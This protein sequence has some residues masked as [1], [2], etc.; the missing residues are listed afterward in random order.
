MFFTLLTLFTAF[1]NASNTP[2]CE[3]VYDKLGIAHVNVTDQSHYYYCF[4]HHHGRD[5]A[6]QMD[7]FKRVAL[8]KNAELYGFSALKTDLMM[9]L[10][11]LPQ[12]ADRLFNELPSET[13]KIL[14]DYANGVNAGFKTGKEAREFK[15]LDYTPSLWMPQDS[16]L[17][18]LLQSFDQTKKTFAKDYE[19]EKF[20]EHWGKKVESLF[21]EDNVPWVNTILKEGEYSK[22]I[23]ISKK[24]TFISN[25]IKLWAEFPEVFGR[26]S[27]S[28]N[29]VISKQKSKTGNALLANDP[30]LDLKTPLFLYWIHLHGEKTNAIGASVPGVPVIVS[31]TNGRV[32]WGLTNA[33][34]NTADAVFVKDLPADYIE[35]VRPIVKF[36]FGPFLIPFFFK[37]FERTQDGKPVLP[38]ELATERKIILKWTG[39]DLKG[40]DLAPMFN[41]VSSQSIDEVDKHLQGVGLPAWNFV[42]ADNKGSIGYRV[43]GEAYKMTAQDAVGIEEEKFHDFLKPQLLSANERPSVLRPSRHYI[44]TANNRHWPRDS[45]YY[46]GRGYSHM[47][48]GYRIDELLRDQK[49]DV[50][51]FKKVQCDRQAV[52]AQFFVPLLL[53]YSD[54]PELKKWDFSTIDES[55][56]VPIYRR[57]MD[58]LLQDWKVNEY[59]LYRLL[60][61]PDQQ[62]LKQLQSTLDAV[63]AE[64]KQRPWGEVHRLRFTHI[65]KNE[66]WKFS[67]E[68]PGFGD[69]HSVDPGTASW[70]EDSNTYDHFSGASMRMIIEMAPTPQIH[71]SLPGKNRNYSSNDSSFHPWS[72]WKSCQYEKIS[73]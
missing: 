55:F 63:R 58:R 31:G 11:N 8:G 45:Q 71:L 3:A 69:L 34:I 9:R 54:I 62:Q 42:F 64:V 53:K 19:E 15:E 6:W 25:P 20:K 66:N 12:L 68:L 43:V 61:K 2:H 35:S 13:K 17:I 10:L 1:S 24:T 72:H 28:N 70:D 57:L 51:T 44:Y 39:F 32:A 47:F 48:R 36:K 56:A 23:P 29:W 5:R 18:L 49:H 41:I 59:A 26:E 14:Q 46:G 4:G 7:Y 50:E 65:S 60:L 22:V 52:D 33:Y 21:S 16:V 30:H 38:M 37:S 40:Q 27:G 67:P 73:Y